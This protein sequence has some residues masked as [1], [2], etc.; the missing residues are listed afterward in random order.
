MDVIDRFQSLCNYSDMKKKNMAEVYE[1]WISKPVNLEE[2]ETENEDETKQVKKYDRK[3]KTNCKYCSKIILTA[4]LS[5]HMES[6]VGIQVFNFFL[7]KN[8]TGRST[9]QDCHKMF[10]YYM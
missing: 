3:A 2:A 10:Q 4:N 5:H 9:C 6:C 8:N 1:K 7:G